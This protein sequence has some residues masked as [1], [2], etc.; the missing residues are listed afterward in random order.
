MKFRDSRWAVFPVICSIIYCNLTISAALFYQYQS[1]IKAVCGMPLHF[2]GSQISC[3]E[4]SAIFR[5]HMIIMSHSI[6]TLSA[7]RFPCVI[8]NHQSHSLMDGWDVMKLGQM[9]V[10]LFCTLR[11]HIFCVSFV[12]NQT[13]EGS[14]NH[15]AQ[16]ITVLLLLIYRAVI[17]AVAM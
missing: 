8:T 7:P 17:F 4:T 3:S 1:L 16:K 12:R 14:I 10:S 6:P 9:I 15:P 2:V 5:E 13:T 11:F